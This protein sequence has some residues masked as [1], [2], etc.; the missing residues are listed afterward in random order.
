MYITFKKNNFYINSLIIKPYMNCAICNKQEE[1]FLDKNV[2]LFLQKNSRGIIL[3]NKLRKIKY[4]ISPKKY[5]LKIKE[6]NINISKLLYLYNIIPDCIWNY[7]NSYI[8]V[9]NKYDYLINKELDYLIFKLN[10]I[11]SPKSININ[12]FCNN[13]KYISEYSNCLFCYNN[14][15]LNSNHLCINCSSLIN[16]NF[17][18]RINNIIL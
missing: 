2:L 16:Y 11:I 4:K 14:E 1:L 9:K 7:I 10:N 3:L 5:K 17:Y 13:C 12:L 6:I 8:D 15:L 18:N